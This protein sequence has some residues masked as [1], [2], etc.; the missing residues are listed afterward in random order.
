MVHPELVPI[1]RRRVG[2]V[3]V[4]VRGALRPGTDRRQAL[5]R[6]RRA[7]EGTVI[8]P[9]PHPMSATSSAL[10]TCPASWPHLVA[11]L[12]LGTV[13]HSLVSSTRRRRRDLAVL[14]D[15]WLCPPTSLGH[16]GLAS[17]HLRR[18]RHSGRVATWHRAGAWAWRL[19][20]EELG[21]ATPPVTPLLSTLAIAAGTSWPP[22]LWAAPP[23]WVAASLDGARAAFGITQR[24]RRVGVSLCD[25]RSLDNERWPWEP[26]D[27]DRHGWSWFSRGL[28]QLERRGE[29][30]R[31]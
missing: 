24:G 29:A 25:V 5:A 31:V 3:C 27:R 16:R 23:G 10:A 26:L 9:R 12:A 20:A 18:S 19:T 15:A 8:P 14:Q 2:S 1:P 13:A 17:H 11:L 6:L 30:A 22:N 7:Y 21:V 28:L 4:D